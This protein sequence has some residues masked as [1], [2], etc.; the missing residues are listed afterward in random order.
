MRVE[1]Q[2]VPDP[3]SMV[4]AT[5]K[6]TAEEEQ[7]VPGERESFA[8]QPPLFAFVPSCLRSGATFQPATAVAALMGVYMRFF[9]S[10]PLFAA[11]TA[12]AAAASF[13]LTQH[14]FLSKGEGG[15]GV[16]EE[17][18]REKEKKDCTGRR[19]GGAAKAQAEAEVVA[20][21]TAAGVCLKAA[22][23]ASRQHR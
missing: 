20:V 23:G 12:A 9:P 5:A 3:I 2:K 1:Q 6:A 19:E 14:T 16:E 11:A 22:T 17:G 7:R 18:G 8:S 21:E 10:L 15:E 13:S 4:K